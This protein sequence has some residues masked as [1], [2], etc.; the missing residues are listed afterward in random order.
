MPAAKAP[1]KFQDPSIVQLSDEERIS[2]H[3]TE[4]NLAIAITALHRDGLVVL[5]N[6]VDVE[7][8]DQ[9]NNLLSTEA[10]EM[11]KLP[12]T[13]F[14]DV[15]CYNSPTSKASLWPCWALVRSLPCRN[16]S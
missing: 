7:H 2:G 16:G 14:N 13:H 10:E 11:A 6:A 8:V 3:I 1:Y 15:S 5:E 12:T 4:E 9:L